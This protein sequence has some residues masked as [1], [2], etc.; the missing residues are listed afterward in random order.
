MR[1]I[2]KNALI[3]YPAS[4]MFELVDDIE[5]YPRFLPWC[6]D[7]RILRREANLVE[8]ELEIARGAFQQSFAT[9]NYNVPGREIR[10]TLLRGPFSHLEGLWRF[11]PLRQDAS[12]ITLQ[13]SFA[14]DSRIG[15][16]AFGAM[17]NQICE[18]M[19]EAFTRRARQI[20]G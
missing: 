13:L 20:H 18:T 6:R 16:L 19:V 8:A 2:H 9:R 7:S 14:M 15:S 12:K 4:K 3:R 17:F 5:S 11:Q 10:M 1:T